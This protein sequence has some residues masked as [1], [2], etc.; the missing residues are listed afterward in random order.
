MVRQAGERRASRWATTSRTPPGTWT[1][2]PPEAPSG[3]LQ[4]GQLAHEQGVAAGSLHD[5]GH[6]ARRE[7]AGGH[8]GGQVGGVVRGKSFEGDHF[9]AAHQPGGR[10]GGIDIAERPD[11]QHPGAPHVTREEGQQRECRLVGPVQVV[12]S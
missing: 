6:G 2:W 4:K 9:G 10:R 5:V 7:A 3:G 12:E 11:D 1:G 8:G